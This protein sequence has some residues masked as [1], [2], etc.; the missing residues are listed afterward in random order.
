MT[1]YEKSKKANLTADEDIENKKSNSGQKET[2]CVKKS[3]CEYPSSLASD[4]KLRSDW[5]KKHVP[6]VILTLIKISWLLYNQ[7]V[8]SAIVVTVGY[9][10]YVFI[11]EL[12]TEP[13]W[14]SEIGNWHR[15]GFN[16]IVALIDIFLLAYPVCIMHFVYTVAYGWVYALVTFIFWLQDPVNNIIYTEIDYKRPYFVLTGYFGLTALTFVL[17]IVHFFAYRLKLSFRYGCTAFK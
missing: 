6:C 10:S 2:Y 8:I 15:H 16:S 5:I 3:A 12:E 9:F 13:T 7:I 17:Q 14:F 11:T 1:T 4:A